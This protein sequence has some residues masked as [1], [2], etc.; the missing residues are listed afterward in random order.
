MRE[1][2]AQ[3]VYFEQPGRANAERT[4]EL[5]YA[6][7]KE[8]GLHTVLVATTRGDTGVRAVQVL[9]G[10]EIVAVTHETGHR[11]PNAQDL[12]PENRA[13]IETAGGRILT[14]QH[15]FAGV[16]RAVRKKLGAYQLD[17]IIAYTLRTFGQGMK[18]VIEIALMAADA[19]LVRTD[20]PVM[21]IAGSGH[22]ADMAAVVLPTNS[23]TFFQVRVVEV[24]CRPSQEHP[25]FEH[26]RDRA[27][28]PEDD[29]R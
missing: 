9:K 24:V 11:A 17:E 12:T 13:A 4:L 21:C 18:V 27:T 22:G 2:C 6:R 14:C 3:T 5:A 8:L 20:A 28:S 15:A 16:N 19:G 23:H 10:M 1:L 25:A 26:P 7:A 29:A